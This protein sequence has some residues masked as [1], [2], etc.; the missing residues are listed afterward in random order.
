MGHVMNA[1]R[2]LTIPG[3]AL[4][5]YFPAVCFSLSVEEQN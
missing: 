1:M 5:A 3:A 4:M 2:I